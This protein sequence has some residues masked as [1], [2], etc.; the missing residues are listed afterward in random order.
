MHSSDDDDDEWDAT[1]PAALSH[2]ATRAPPTPDRGVASSPTSPRDQ[3][4]VASA[5]MYKLHA[6][7]ELDEDGHVYDAGVWLSPMAEKEKRRFAKIGAAV[8]TRHMF[9]GAKMV[10]SKTRPAKAGDSPGQDVKRSPTS[11]V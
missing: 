9:S 7:K 10:K 8:N 11:F 4:V 2:A 3:A 5:H 6:D 1:S